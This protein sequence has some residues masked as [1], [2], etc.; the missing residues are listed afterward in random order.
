MGTAC[1]PL[2]A[3]QRM[4]GQ[5]QEDQQFKVKLNLNSSL[6]ITQHFFIYVYYNHG[7]PILLLHLFVLTKHFVIH[8][9]LFLYFFE[10]YLMLMNIE[11]TYGNN[12]LLTLP[13][14]LIAAAGAEKE[15]RKIPAATP[16]SLILPF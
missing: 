8:C 12:A 10:Q 4:K 11:H 6:F 1:P 2:C 3:S 7:L 9:Q 5:E 13:I 14:Q 15:T 16:A